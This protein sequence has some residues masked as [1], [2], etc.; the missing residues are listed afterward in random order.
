MM[1]NPL[2][3]IGN[4]NKHINGHSFISNLLGVKLMGK[5]CEIV[6]INFKDR[7]STLV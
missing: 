6:I 1:L 5:T 2:Y 4:L 3:T 7:N